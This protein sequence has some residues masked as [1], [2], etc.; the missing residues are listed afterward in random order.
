MMIVAKSH[1]A[2]PSRT[3]LVGETM[4]ALEGIIG[5]KFLVIVLLLG[6]I[7]CPI[8]L[9]WPLCYLLRTMMMR[10]LLMRVM[11]KTPGMSQP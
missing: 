1:A 4:F 2:I 8:P 3:V 5:L 9:Q 7:I 6:L 11:M 10:L